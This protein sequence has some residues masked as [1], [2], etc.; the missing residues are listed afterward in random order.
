ML[1]ADEVVYLSLLTLI[2]RAMPPLAGSSS[3][4]NQTCIDVARKALQSHQSCMEM[5]EP[6]DIFLL[7]AY[8]NW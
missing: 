1:K 6:T 5:I 4:F 2:Y 7:S 8:I 3:A